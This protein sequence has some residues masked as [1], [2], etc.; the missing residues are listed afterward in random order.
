MWDGVFIPP[1]AF[2]DVSLDTCLLP[3]SEQT[4]QPVLGPRAIGK[5]ASPGPEAGRRCRDQEGKRCWCKPEAAVMAERTLAPE[6]GCS[7]LTP[8]FLQ[9]YVWS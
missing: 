8:D 3:V 4:E 7:G 1:E 6:L 2:H 9:T 5:P